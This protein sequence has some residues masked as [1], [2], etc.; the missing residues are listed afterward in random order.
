[1]SKNKLYIVNVFRWGE[2][3]KHSYFVGVFSKKQKAIDEAKKEENYRGGKYKAEII[4]AEINISYAEDQNPWAKRI[5][6]ID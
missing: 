3:D 5:K 4:E 1:M 6:D 2:R